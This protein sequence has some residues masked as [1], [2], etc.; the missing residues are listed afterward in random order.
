MVFAGLDSFVNS[1]GMY[2]DSGGLNSG[3][4]SLIR[5]L[6]TEF[7][8]VIESNVIATKSTALST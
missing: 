5:L 7:D 6:T 2:C 8:Q 1:Q 3:R 4:M